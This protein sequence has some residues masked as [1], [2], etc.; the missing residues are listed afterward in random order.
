MSNDNRQFIEDYS[1]IQ[2]IGPEKS[3]IQD[4][5]ENLSYAKRE[6]VAS[7]FSRR[8]IRNVQYEE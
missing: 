8:L 2:A 3:W 6:I 7:Q 5:A 1:P 4:L